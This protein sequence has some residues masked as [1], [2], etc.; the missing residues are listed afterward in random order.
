MLNVG[1]GEVLVI[2]LVALLVL[3]PDKLPGAARTAGKVMRQVRDISGGFQDEV[4][5][6]MDDDTTVSA[7]V[8]GA[9]AG[10]DLHPGAGAG[11]SLPP[12]TDGGDEPDATSTGDE[13]AA[14]AGA[15]RGDV[16]WSTDGPSG[17]FS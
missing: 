3:G 11:P 4:R 13:P 12:A 9:S 17:S 2:L 10:S 15:D 6:A 5:K 16:R 7:P 14:D 8:P 1:G